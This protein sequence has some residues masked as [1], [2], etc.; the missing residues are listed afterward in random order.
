MITTDF[1]PYPRRGQMVKGY[2]YSKPISFNEVGWLAS[3]HFPAECIQ[4]CARSGKVD[5]DV[6]NWLVKLHLIKALHPHRALV[7]RY[8]QEFGA[9]DDLKT[10]KLE[11]LAARVLWV[12]CCEIKES[13]EWAGL[14][15]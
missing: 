8:L 3:G 9:W 1:K 11:V 15:H 6:A 4:E 7:E 13:G 14:V 2:K 12:A 5:Y 10:A